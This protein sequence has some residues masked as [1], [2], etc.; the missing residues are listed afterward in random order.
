[1]QERRRLQDAGEE[2]KQD[3]EASRRDSR[4]GRGAPTALIQN[5]TGGELQDQD[6]IFISSCKSCG[7]RY[8][9]EDIDRIM[10]FLDALT[11]PGSIDLRGDQDVVKGVPSGLPL[12]D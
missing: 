5:L 1:M 2:R 12:D 4:R 10:D 8:S 3:A 6:E 7:E 11:D 9:K